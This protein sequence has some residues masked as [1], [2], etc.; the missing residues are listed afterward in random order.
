MTEVKPYLGT[1]V[2]QKTVSF[3]PSTKSA[4]SASSDL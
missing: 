1:T 2:I 3:C 4:W